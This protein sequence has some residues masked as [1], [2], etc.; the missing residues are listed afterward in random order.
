MQQ[1][2]L[3]PRASDR[4][5]DSLVAAID[6]Y[7]PAVLLTS[8]QLRRHIRALIADRHF[9]VPVLSYNELIPTLKLEV[10]YQVVPNESAQLSSV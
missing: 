9:D 5:R 1:L 4:L 6:K 3:D 8:V 10:L 7:Q 2:S